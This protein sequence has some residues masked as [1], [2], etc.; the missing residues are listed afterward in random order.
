[1]KLMFSKRYYLC[2]AFADFLLANSGEI[3]GILDQLE[4]IGKG[5]GWKI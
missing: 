3:D 5:H 1:M 4:A 2:I